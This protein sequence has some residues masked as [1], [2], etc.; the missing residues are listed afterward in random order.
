MRTILDLDRY[1]IEHA[2]SPEVARLVAACQAGLAA[3]GMFNLDGFVRQEAI[4]RAAAEI[5]PRSAHGAYTHQRSH[6]VYF[7]KQLSGLP[8]DHPALRQFQ[9]I[10]HTLCDDQLQ[11][12]I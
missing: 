2:D 3:T 12:T 6:N 7:E 9:T 10:H 11:G 1:P 8:A 5:L 4:E